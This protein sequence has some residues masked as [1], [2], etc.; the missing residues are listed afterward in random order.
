MHSFHFPH[1]SSAF[2]LLS[3]FLR[4]LRFVLEFHLACLPEQHASSWGLMCAGPA[5]GTYLV[6]RSVPTAGLCRA[7]MGRTP[8]RWCP[9]PC[10]WDRVSLLAGALCLAGCRKHSGAW[11]QALPPCSQR[12]SWVGTVLAG[13][14]VDAG[15]SAAWAGAGMTPT[16]LPPAL[17]EVQFLK[18]SQWFKTC[19]P[20][21]AGVA[22]SRPSVWLLHAWHFHT[23]RPGLGAAQY[24]P[25]G[26]SQ[27]AEPPRDH[28]ACCRRRNEVWVAL[29]MF[30]SDTSDLA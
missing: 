21:C 15:R 1:S 19:R 27:L 17:W 28:D 6:P 5:L 22:V 14:G 29:Q 8:S 18:I 11:S 13:N 7:A 10:V 25:A 30:W 23:W 16:G 26:V 4:G 24:H 3:V 2:G 20:F 9:C 12:C